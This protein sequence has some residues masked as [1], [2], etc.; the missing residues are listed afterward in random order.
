M[1]IHKT[2]PNSPKVFAKDSNPKT[3]AFKQITPPERY[4]R[5]KTGRRD[6]TIRAEM[7]CRFFATKQGVIP[8]MFPI[9]VGSPPNHPLKNRVFHYFHHLF[10]VFSPY[11]WKHPHV[12]QFTWSLKYFFL[13]R[14]FQNISVAAWR[15]A[16][17]THC[18]V[19]FHFHVHS[20]WKTCGTWKIPH[21]NEL[22]E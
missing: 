18:H 20:P 22:I 11:F 17:R 10:W 6:V 16:K 1:Q 21:G 5:R 15:G 19:F 8:W 4:W 2:P 9:I 14:I 3:A 7:P 12:P 13:M